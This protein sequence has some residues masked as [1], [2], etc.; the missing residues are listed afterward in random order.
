MD[1]VGVSDSRSLTPD[2]P[3][4]LPELLLSLAKW[5]LEEKVGSRRGGGVTMT[6]VQLI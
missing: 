6:V 1:G 3:E 5:S 4:F 2:T